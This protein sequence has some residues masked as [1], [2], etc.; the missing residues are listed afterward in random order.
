[1]STSSIN[2]ENTEKAFAYKSDCDLKKAR[3]LFTFMKSSILV[4]IATKITPWLIKA[5]FPIKNLIKRTLFDQFVGGLTLENTGLVAK[6]LSRFN[7]QVILDFGIEGGEKNDHQYDAITK[8]F[9][10]VISFASTQQNIPFISIKITGLTSIALLEKLN[11]S[12][13]T[14]NTT[15]QLA[16]EDRIT[17]LT[18][19]EANQWNNLLARMESISQLAAE[20]NIGLMIDAEES[21]IQEPIDYI[22]E[23][24][25]K[26]YNKEEV[27]VYN[28]IQ[29]YRQD[30]LAFLINKFNLARENK[31]ILGVKLVRGAYME[32]ENRRADKLSYTTPIHLSKQAT[33]HDFN[34]AV[35]FCLTNRE[36]ISTIIASH[37]ESSNLMATKNLIDLSIQANHPH[38]HFSQLYGMSDNLTFNLS[39]A[40]FNASKYLPFGPI[41]EVIPYLMRRAEENSSIS[42]Q[43]T[44]ELNLITKECLRRSL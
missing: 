36:F 27:I 3:F 10:D 42:G 24:L 33:D 9:R 13:K 31:Y 11:S 16:F 37:N 34:E 30:R 18:T 2:L 29:L 1:M 23:L 14:T 32:K 4:K 5:G 15:N 17:K 39:D 38:V 28:T 7:V 19:Y 12:A 20:K 6:T 25:M 8:Q 22:A 40:G 43:T 41:E 26:K 21:W 35:E 44:R